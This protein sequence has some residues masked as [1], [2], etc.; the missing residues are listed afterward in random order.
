MPY[1]ITIDREDGITRVWFEGTTTGRDIIA[2]TD[3]LVAH[4]GYD[5]TFDQ[6]WSLADVT[7]LLID[8]EEMVDLVANDQ[9]LVESG[10]MGRVRVAIV[11]AGE[12][13]KLAI[14]L[15]EYQMRA[16]GQEIRLFDTEGEAEAW[17]RGEHT[18]RKAG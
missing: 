15:Y 4:S 1:T 11:V 3:D 18:E 9:A 2:A 16:S 17:L 12:L 14:H 6:F 10:Q 7:E 13:R 5:D 8:S